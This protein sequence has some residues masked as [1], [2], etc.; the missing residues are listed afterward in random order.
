MHLL[1]T[2]L[3][4]NFVSTRLRTFQIA[5]TIGARWAAKTFLLRTCQLIDY[6][7]RTFTK[8][9]DHPPM[10]YP[11]NAAV[12]FLV[13]ITSIIAVAGDVTIPKTAWKRGIGV[14]LENPGGRKRAL[15]GMIDDGYW[16]GAPVGG[17]GAGTLSRT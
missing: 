14:P 1:A 11:R 10:R 3:V 7:G 15:V 6:T 13:L 16:Q 17:F 2:R 5:N 8:A 9:E 4:W 12:I